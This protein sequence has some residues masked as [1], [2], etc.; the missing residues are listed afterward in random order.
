MT[1]PFTLIEALGWKMPFAVGLVA[2]ILIG[3]E[4]IAS[5]LEYV[6]LSFS[7]P[8]LILIFEK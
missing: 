1:L 2:F 8:T 7:L 4:S 5:E 6:S 3:I